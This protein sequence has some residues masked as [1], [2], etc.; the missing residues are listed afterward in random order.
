LVLESTPLVGEGLM[1][2][3]ASRRWAEADAIF[4]RLLDLE[5]GE[6]ASALA[7]MTL[8]PE[9]RARVERLL[10]AD[11][12]AMTRLDRPLL[13]PMQPRRPTLAGQVLGRW[14][15]GPEIG[16][17]GMAV[18]HAAEAIDQPGLRAAVK[19]LTTG[20]LA[21]DGLDRF[22]REQAILAR[23]SH[24]HIAPLLDAGL[25]AD[26]TPWLAMARVE[27]LRIDDWCRQRRADVST[28][29]RLVLDVC[30]AVAHAHQALVIHRDLKP[31]NVLVDADGHVRLLDFGIARLVDDA[32]GERT[33]TTHRALTPD[34]AAPEQFAGAPPSTAIDVWGIGALLYQLLTGRPPR[35]AAALDGS[36]T[37]PSRAV[38]DDQFGD[39]TTTQR[40]RREQRGDLDAI[41]LKAL[42]PEPAQRYPS[43]SLLAEDLRRWLDG[44]PV[45]AQPPTLRYRA[46]KFVRRHRGAVAA[47]TI[48]VLAI[49]GGLAVSLWQA[50]RA[51]RAATEAR[52]QAERAE[53]QLRRAES[54]AEF[55][56]RLFDASD[57]DRPAAERPTLESL[58]AGGARQALEATDLDPAVQA[59]ML[60]TIG[61]VHLLAGQPDRG[62]ELIETAV[63]RARAAGPAASVELAGALH[64]R[65]FARS[66]GDS[67][68]LEDTD[69]AEA[70]AILQR[71]QPQSKLRLEIARRRAFQRLAT[72]DPAAAL[73]VLEP[74]LDG[75]W[76]GPVPT[77]D[78]RIRLLD[79]VAMARHQ[80]GDMA[81]AR[82]AFAES[83]ALERAAGRATT[84]GFAITLANSAAA[85]IEGGD[86]ALA[87]SRTRE[88]IAIHDRIGAD[89]SGY[90]ASARLQ[91]GKTLLAA[92]R[93]DEARDALEASNREWA[94]LRSLDLEDYPFTHLARGRLAAAALDP[95]A[96]ERH[97]ARFVEL[98]GTQRQD[99]SGFRAEV[100]AE[101]AIAACA[102]GRIA[103]GAALRTEAEAAL[104]KGSH[105]RN[106]ARLALAIAAAGCALAE[107]DPARALAQLDDPDLPRSIEA[108]DPARRLRL[109]LV[110]C[111]ALRALARDAECVTLARA[112]VASLDHA[113]LGKHP[114]RARFEALVAR[115]GPARR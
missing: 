81:G 69:L 14:R 48:A 56:T 99:I 70:E 26:G 91:L 16:R 61:R 50:H 35:A 32:D 52:A 88:A 31:G 114:Y 95:A 46:G 113:G 82:R 108:L 11:A 38:A 58:L 104:A 2:E 93:F 43:V 18:V 90:R 40:A 23:L 111:E 57:P 39:A 77:D 5:P 17:G 41:V 51:E 97:F 86:L 62:L 68:Q 22:R 30:D 84:R 103:E 89:P 87:E 107:G 3:A 15:L 45:L 75:R 29:V 60:T 10:A 101:R 78:D 106:A 53:D 33:A 79:T 49:L 74:I 9:V 73:A 66:R 94:A 36:L 19:L 27:G 21:A 67:T 25:T 102:A 110:R 13:P 109:D 96:S 7:A 59:R 80:V 28:R 65:A 85:E 20:A 6:R 8:D 100:D 71:H 24:P 34:Y 12:E 83:I 115:D 54:L 47:A 112:A 37:R 76:D 72:L 1:D 92:G 44:Q 42:A 98:A 4:D 64:W 63:E 105:D 55:L